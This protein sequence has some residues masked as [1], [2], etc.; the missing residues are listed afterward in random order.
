MPLMYG[1]LLATGLA[2]ARGHAPDR[3]IDRVLHDFVPHLHYNVPAA[4]LFIILSLRV[5]R[6]RIA[7]LSAGVFSMLFPDALTIMWYTGMVIA[8]FIHPL[9]KSR[10][11]E[12]FLLGAFPCGVIA[13]LSAFTLT[14]AGGLAAARGALAAVAACEA[15]LSSRC[16]LVILP[17]MYK[18]LFFS[19]TVLLSFL[20][21]AADLS[22]QPWP[23]HVID[24]SSRGADGVRRM[25]VN[26]DGLLDVVTGWEEGGTVR[27][28]L[29]PGHV[30]VRE[31]WPSVNVG[32]A[33]DV[34]D[35]VFADIDA[36]GA[37]D[38][39]SAS[40]GETRSLWV[41]WAPRDGGYMDAAAWRTEPVP[42]SSGTRWMFSLPV[43]IDGRNGIDFVAGGKTSE[44]GWWESP[45]DP[46]DL[47]A[48]R[49]HA[50]R[51]CGWLMSLVPYDMD[52][53]G[54]DD[55][56]FSDR[57]ESLRGCYWFENPG[58]GSAAA[59]IAPWACHVIGG[60]EHEVMFLAVAPDPANGRLTLL[61]ATRANALLM[62]LQDANGAWS[63]RVIPLPDAT[64]TAKGVAFGDIDG[65][66]VTDAAVTCENAR[67][68][69]GVFW[70]E[71]VFAWR[72]DPPPLHGI[73]GATG[74]KYDLA[75]L[76]DLDG[77]GDL[78][79]MTCEEAENLGVIWYENPARR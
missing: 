22:P 37:V 66:G 55:I 56:V 17:L 67:D 13:Y 77:D 52:A 65:D 11:L 61:A 78:D 64:G 45:A 63:E 32:Q 53:D 15:F 62:M 70:L 59:V 79:L 58:S 9:W 41:H 3:V 4:G 60:T 18:R 40:E 72:D 5:D 51:P 20:A 10:L 33:G 74:T 43:D 29:H 68:K 19:F 76:D 73:S 6:Y 34:E 16:S 36:D 12:P 46:R 21:H 31:P 26:G 27:A 71:D 1:G 24:A 8:G 75:V 49:W 7:L 38:V 14:G 35:A 57:R 2:V 54:D 39:I 23:R 48:W 44:L 69:L 50:W 42:A 30:R 28:C 47:E 25:D